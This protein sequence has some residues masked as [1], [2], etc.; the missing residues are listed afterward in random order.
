M[1]RG[2]GGKGNGGG[3]VSY[4]EDNAPYVP[5][6]SPRRSRIHHPST[7]EISDFDFGFRE[8]GHEFENGHEYGNGYGNGNGGYGRRGSGGKYYSPD[9]IR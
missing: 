4:V 6:R 7:S 5:T 9:E 1:M 8:S 2:L 3:R